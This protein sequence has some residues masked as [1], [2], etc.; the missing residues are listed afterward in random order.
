MEN[1]YA[2]VR[3]DNGMRNPHTGIVSNHK[4]EDAAREAIERAN[5]RLQK[6]AGYATAWHPYA[7]LDRETGEKN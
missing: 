6:Q 5:R 7:V 4:T 3:I 1:R 2:V